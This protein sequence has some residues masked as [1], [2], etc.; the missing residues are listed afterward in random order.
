MFF[1]KDIIKKNIDNKEKE[2]FTH[3][4]IIFFTDNSKMH[5]IDSENI[6]IDGTFKAP[7]NF[8]KL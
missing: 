1:Y 2:I 7:N 6:L 3:S 8:Y 4:H 5:L